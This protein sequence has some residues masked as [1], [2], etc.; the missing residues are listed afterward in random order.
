MLDDT[1]SKIYDKFIKYIKE[2]G[3]TTPIHET[4]TPEAEEDL[5]DIGITTDALLAEILTA[6][7]ERKIIEKRTGDTEP[8]LT[9]TEGELDRLASE[10]ENLQ[11]HTGRFTRLHQELHLL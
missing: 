7:Q 10:P 1:K 11:L 5:K 3:Y 2:K 8:K 4:I 9:I 6:M